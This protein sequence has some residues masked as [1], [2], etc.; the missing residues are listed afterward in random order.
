MRIS[1]TELKKL[2]IA[3]H[4]NGYCNFFLISRQ[5]KIIHCSYNYV[6]YRE[7]VEKI[8]RTEKTLSNLQT[9]WCQLKYVNYTKLKML[10]SHCGNC[11][12]ETFNF[13]SSIKIIFFFLLNVLISCTEICSYTK[14]NV[15]LFPNTCNYKE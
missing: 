5:Q 13:N 2:S 11:Q 14:K 4:S 15:N 7:G 3:L 8:N 9:Y 10:F 6:L 1:K 12:S